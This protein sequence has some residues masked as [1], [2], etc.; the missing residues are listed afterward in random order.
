MESQ[1]TV[2]T[3][4]DVKPKTNEDSDEEEYLESPL[5]DGD[6]YDEHY[7]LEGGDQEETPMDGMDD[8]EVTVDVVKK[9]LA[10]MVS[11]NKLT[12]DQ[13]EYYFVKFATL[14]ATF[15]EAMQK[16]ELSKKQA[17]ELRE[18][19]LEQKSNADQKQQEKKMRQLR[20]AELKREFQKGEQQ[21]TL[22]QEQDADQNM[23]II[24]QERKISELEQQVMK[25]KELREAREK[26]IIVAYSEDIKT[27]KKQIEKYEGNWKK[28]QD[29]QKKLI[30]DIID[31][32]NEIDDLDEE[33]MAYKEKYLLIKEDPTRSKEQ[34]E[35]V[36]KAVLSTQR[37]LSERSN[38][39]MQ[40]NTKI[41]EQDAKKE[42][43]INTT[44]VMY[45]QEE[46]ELKKIAGIDKEIK[47]YKSKYL[48][49]VD[50]HKQTSAK[51]FS[52]QQE[53]KHKTKILQDHRDMLRQ[54]KKEHDGLIRQIHK[55]Q[56]NISFFS[57][58]VESAATTETKLLEDNMHYESQLKEREEKLNGLQKDIDLLIHKFLNDE[59]TNKEYADSL[60]AKDTDIKELEKKIAEMHEEERTRE[61]SIVN[62]TMDR[63]KMA[64][65]ASKSKQMFIDAMGDVKAA[66]FVNHELRKTL[67]EVEAK[68]KQLMKLYSLVKRDRNKFAQAIQ[69]NIQMLAQITDN[70]KIL[71]NEQEVLT[72]KSLEKE[73][74][75][76]KIRRQH[77]NVFSVRNKL[78]EDYS[79]ADYE[80]QKQQK[81]IDESNNEIAKLEAIIATT[82]NDMLSLKDQYEFRIQERNFAGLQLVDRNDELCILY[83]KSNMQESLI[84][85]GEIELRQ[86][87]Q[88]KKLLTSDLE[89]VKRELAV[90]R[91]NM[92]ELKAKRRE[93]E[94][95]L[96]K[97][98]E[99]KELCE[100]YSDELEN[101]ANDER[102]RKLPGNVPTE[103]E[104]DEQIQTLEKKKNFIDE[105]LQE[106]QLIFEE[107]QKASDS[108]R[109]MAVTSRDQTFDLAVGVNDI[110][111]KIRETNSKMMATLSELSIYQANLMALESRNTQL[112]SNLEKGMQR[113]QEGKAPHEALKA[114]YEKY[115]ELQ[116]KRKEQIRSIHLKQDLLRNQPASVTRTTA[117]QRPTAYIPDN[118]FAVPQP[119]L[120]KPMM[121]QETSA[122]MRHYTK[123]K[124]KKIII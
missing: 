122:N 81:L 69:E 29:Q 31:L 23:A 98:K 52:L 17:K 96:R 119:Y 116:A 124:T 87:R 37:D 111:A 79:K 58:A 72:R 16:E 103:E 115:K 11:K 2:D 97:I 93:R 54:K 38:E 89:D 35:I 92:P 107:V 110:Q 8:Y 114:E 109:G 51:A 1:L 117:I 39:I 42:A 120:M 94:D 71:E 53:L 34:S 88:Q 28:Y 66:S 10:D 70:K 22:A 20:L 47:K 26:P 74:Q 106:K 64:R 44:Y 21:L 32:E 50:Q 48:Q 102:W 100:A 46:Q 15:K 55:L 40:M 85:K 49:E 63:E 113:L 61:R 105:Q 45:M 36:N 82:E 3:Q 101:H 90:I 99:A 6:E 9:Q 7:D 83:E 112:Q 65:E 75:L 78:R 108:L 12:S 76:I 95:L 86:I 18:Q 25:N 27:L 123:P 118:E 67:H 60:R 80:L 5:P 43:I 104:L 68:N 84:R 91:K 77:D 19:Y 30:T 62:L 57:K 121:F 59:L 24:D 41:K 33:S 4:S 56:S 73:K 13:Y 14:H